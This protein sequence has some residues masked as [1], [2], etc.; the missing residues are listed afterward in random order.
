MTPSAEPPLRRELAAVQSAR[1]VVV[2]GTFDG[3][4][5]GHRALIA[6]TVEVAQRLRR[7]W[8]PVAFFPPPKTL[9]AGHAFLSSEREKH[10]LLVEA[11]RDAG[12]APAEVVVVAFDADVAATP[13][14]AF[15]AALAALRPSAVVVGE[16][17][18]F[19]RG[20]RGGI[21][22]LRATA[23]QLEVLPLVAIGDE[24]VKS[25][26]VRDALD[27]GDVERAA[28]LLCAPYR[29]V[30]EVVRGDQRG[31]TIGV[32]TANL[33]LDPRK[34]LPEGVF[35]VTVDLP[36]GT[37]RGAMAN[38]GPR[39]SFAGPSARV[40]AHLFDVDGDLYG[41]TLRV[42]LVARLRAQRRFADLAELRAQLSEDARAARV[43]LGLVNH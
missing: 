27:A 20:R 35:A 18:R 28:E 40:E 36:D 38:L 41:A 25:S 42:H 43:R 9:L 16:D 3:V 19:G 39:P 30:G 17:F 7:P 14:E 13:A 26:L 4:H 1:P 22:M 32:P 8:V 37:R 15:A 21:D 31:R 33:D 24:V 5:C 6:H 23:D 2:L 11:G 10:E 12:A 29:V 34:A